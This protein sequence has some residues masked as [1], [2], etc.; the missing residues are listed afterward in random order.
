[1]VNRAF[2]NFYE[3]KKGRAIDGLSK[4]MS[5][6]DKLTTYLHKNALL[7]HLNISR[8]RF[9]VRFGAKRRNS[10]PPFFFELFLLP[11][12][13]LSF[14]MVVYRTNCITSIEKKTFTSP[15]HK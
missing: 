14:K 9:M 15:E 1:M 10:I 13:T 12:N 5:F 6:V 3:G 4:K 11:S 7:H 8:L 2:M